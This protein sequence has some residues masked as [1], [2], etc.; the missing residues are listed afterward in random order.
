MKHFPTYCFK[1]LFAVILRVNRCGGR[2][3]ERPA[4]SAYLDPADFVRDMI[5]YR[6]KTERS[7]SVHRSTKK[8]RRVSPALVSLVVQKKRK[9]ALDR[10]DE[11]A[12]LMDLNVSEKFFFRNWVGQLS[13]KDFLES[14]P[15]AEQ[16]RKVAGTSILSDWINLYGKDL[17]LIPQV[18]KKPELAE[19]QLRQ[20]TTSRRVS[21]A[22]EFLLREGHLR[23]KLDGSVVIETN[24]SVT[25]P[26]VPSRKIRQF[27][28]GALGLAK[29]ALDLYPVNER[30]ANTLIVALDEKR[31]AELL[32]L[33]KEFAERLQDFAA[34]SVESP[35]RLY[36]VLVNLSP[37]G[38]KLE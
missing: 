15:K 27:H 16:S 3:I 32:E 8:L 17:F 31:H 36:Q 4:I 14:R 29:Q 12:R 22:I 7:F 13:D 5:Q 35:D 25:D 11:F 24:L 34:E 38:R 6:K 9:L 10:A 20:V 19:Q 37:V 18:Q 21:K 33:L 30:M 23:R 26:G 1:R 2:A 28:K